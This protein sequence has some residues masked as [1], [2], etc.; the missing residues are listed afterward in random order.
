MRATWR[1][2]SSDRAGVCCNFSC[3][4]CPGVGVSAG[5]WRL[6][7]TG[8]YPSAGRAARETAQGRP[9]CPAGAPP[10][11]AGTRPPRGQE[12]LARPHAKPRA[13]HDIAPAADGAFEGP[14]AS[15]R[16]TRRRHRPR[17]CSRREVKFLL[18]AHPWSESHSQMEGSQAEDRHNPLPHITVSTTAPKSAYKNTTSLSI[19]TATEL[20]K[21]LEP[22]R[23]GSR[24]LAAASSPVRRTWSRYT[25]AASQPTTR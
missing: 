9:A 16:P 3:A 4:H 1:A 2:H 7:M 21:L 13:W 8:T 19:H 6:L 5:D 24:A 18:P 17:R 20:R 25:L 22:R 11:T 14:G 12:F 15:L 10:G 23:A